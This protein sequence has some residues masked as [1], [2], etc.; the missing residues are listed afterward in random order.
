MLTIQEEP[1]YKRNK[2]SKNYIFNWISN[3][4][5]NGVKNTE[6]NICSHKLPNI[7]PTTKFSNDSTNI[8][9]LLDKGKIIKPITNK[10]IYSHEHKRKHKPPQI[11]INNIND[12]YELMPSPSSIFKAVTFN[13]DTPL[14][15]PP[16]PIR[17]QTHSYCTNCYE[18]QDEYTHPFK[19]IYCKI[20]GDE[21]Q[22]NQSPISCPSPPSINPKQSKPIP[23]PILVEKHW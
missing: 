4:I 3:I 15:P 19:C 7:L 8:Y 13:C 12:N 21:Y 23:I 5:E 18:N 2:I 1:N 11:N 20:E 16:P 9:N 14:P 10:S 22:T 17:R 6:N